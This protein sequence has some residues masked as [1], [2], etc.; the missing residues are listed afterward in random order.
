MSS[1]SSAVSTRALFQQSKSAKRISHPLAKYDSLGRL[2]HADTVAEL[3]RR[4]SELQAR[5]ATEH[6]AQVPEKR[7]AAAAIVAYAD[8]SSGSG[9]DADDDNGEPPAKRLVEP[10]AAA[11]A[12]ATTQDGADGNDDDDDGAGQL[13]PG[14]FDADVAE[15]PIDDPPAETAVA[16]AL[17]KDSNLPLDFFDAPSAEHKERRDQELARQ[18][19]EFSKT[20][21]ADLVAVTQAQDQ[22]FEDLNQARDEDEREAQQ[23]LSDKVAQL[24]QRAA[25]AL[26][27]RQAKSTAARPSDNINDDDDDSSDSGGSDIDP[28]ALWR[29]HSLQ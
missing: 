2:R 17:P 16:A 14:F 22:E 21:E 11:A 5:S 20:V 25:A 12:P 4:K 23:T 9:S 7:K 1:S 3:K 18:Y 8:E 15:Q 27:S 6:A 19:E 24:R 29:S 26:A 13:P 10:A 28:D